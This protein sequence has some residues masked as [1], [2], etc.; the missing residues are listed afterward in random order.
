[1]RIRMLV[2]ALLLAGLLAGCGGS[3]DSDDGSDPAPPK[4][5]MQPLVGTTWELDTI[6]DVEGNLTAPP[7][8]APPPTLTFDTRKSATIFTGCNS[9][10]GSVTIKGTDEKAE[11]KFGR[12]ATTLAACVD[13]EQQEIERLFTEALREGGTV[14]LNHG[15]PAMK[16][17]AGKVELIFLPEGLEEE[18]TVSHKYCSS[19]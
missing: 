13:P 8:G 19:R 5:E 3:G 7:E 4:L 11:V 6:A 2:L 1:M 16:F 14:E 9:G 17:T 18:V 10:T 15:T 12:I